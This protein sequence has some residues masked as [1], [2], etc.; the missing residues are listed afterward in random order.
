MLH[1]AFLAGH[2]VV[3]KEGEERALKRLKYAFWVGFKIA[4]EVRRV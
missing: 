4:L 3:E 1:A 2:A